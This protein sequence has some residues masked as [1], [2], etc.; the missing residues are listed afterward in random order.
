MGCQAI[1]ESVSRRQS[2]SRSF[3]GTVRVCVCSDTVDDVEYHVHTGTSRVLD[4]TEAPLCS[5]MH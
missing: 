3:Q 1:V 5:L 2:G 4:P